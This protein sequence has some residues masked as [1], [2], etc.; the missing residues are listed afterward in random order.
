MNWKIALVASAFAT[1]GG[2]I[3]GLG[4]GG[5]DCTRADDHLAECS[6]SPG[7]SG[8]GSGGGMPAAEACTGARACKSQCINQHTCAQIAGNDPGYMLCLGDCQGK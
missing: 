5:D 2:M 6:A 8:S 1:V 4:C 7:S 3:G